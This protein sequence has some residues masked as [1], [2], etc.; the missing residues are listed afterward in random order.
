[1]AVEIAKDKIKFRQVVAQKQEIITVDGD[2][3]VNDVKPDI[4]KVINTNGTICVYREEILDG[5]IKIEGCINTYII[6]LAED[7]IGSIRTINTSLDFAEIIEIENYKEGMTLDET[8][9]IKGFEAKILN[10]RKLHIKA[11]IDANIKVYSNSDVETITEIKNNAEDIQM[12]NCSRRI[13]SL[14]GENT[15]RTTLK[16]TININNEDEFAEIMKLNFAITEVNTKTSYNKI[17]VKANA[18]VDIMYL[19]EDNRINITSAVIPVMGFIEMP[20]VSDISKCVAKTKL[21]NLIV[22]PNNMEEHSI[23]LEADIE[24]FAMAYEDRDINMI[25]DAYSI[26][27]DIN[28]KKNTVNASIE[29]FVLKD[30]YKKNARLTEPELLYGK[31]LGANLNPVIENVEINNGVIKYDGTLKTEV[32][33]NNENNVNTVDVNIPF[34][35]NLSSDKINK[36]SMVETELNTIKQKIYN[37]EDGVMLEAEF[38]INA[39]VQNNEKLSLAQDVEVITPAN[40]ELYSMIIYFVKPGDTL[41]KIAKKFKSRVEDISKINGIEDANKIYVGEQLYIPK[42]TRSRVAIPNG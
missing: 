14:V 40:Q 2:V 4:V 24:L 29:Q 27:D 33:V 13:M 5:K 28:I 31:I 42:F 16:E 10:G 15:G 7:E 41:W 8:L 17:L 12:L 37:S 39:I 34:N 32:M 1:M 22:K 23:Y 6:Y 38:E 30:N 19:T 26:V 35:F 3:I 36:K 21:K 11:F 20:N 18:N 9:C 25:E